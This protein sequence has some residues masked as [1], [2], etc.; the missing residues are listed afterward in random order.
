MRISTLFFAVSLVMLSHA[1]G[2]QCF[3][4]GLMANTEWNMGYHAAIPQGHMGA[5][6]NT[7]HSLAVG[8]FYRLPKSGGR[9]D[10]GLE[11]TAGNYASFTRTQNFGVNGVQT[12]TD[13]TYNSSVTNT[14]AMFRYHY[15]RTENISLFAAVKGGFAAFTSKI[16]IEDPND[17][18]GCEA[19]DEK[20]LISDHTWTAGVRTGA[21]IDMHRFFKKMPQQSLLVQVYGGYTMGGN[22]DYIN[23]KNATT[24]DH[25]GSHSHTPGTA[26]G[27]RPLDVRFVNMQSGAQ[28]T[29]EVAR[30]YNS[31]VR[32]LECGI[33]LV[34]RL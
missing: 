15:F 8:G 20:S 13:V 18:D 19:L 25:S 2:A 14:S 34:M 27:G 12:P 21:N 23:V 24:N 29:H 28:H 22:V 31:P 3:M 17:P 11:I 1:A 26:E 10:V 9:A 16:L 33:S 4:S 6:A 30:V 7:V 32:L 5:H